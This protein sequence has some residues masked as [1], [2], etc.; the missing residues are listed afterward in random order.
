M[1]LNYLPSDINLMIVRVCRAAV[2]VGLMPHQLNFFEYQPF[3]SDSWVDMMERGVAIAEA[4]HGREIWYTRAR[5]N[6][7]NPVILILFGTI[8]GIKESMLKESLRLDKLLE[9]QGVMEA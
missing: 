8:D 9:V 7:D 4:S 3:N 2:K 5:I 1:K 6:N